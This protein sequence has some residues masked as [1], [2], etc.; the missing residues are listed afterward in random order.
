[1]L[2]AR[3]I[4]TATLP[5]GCTKTRQTHE[6]RGRLKH[7]FLRETNAAACQEARDET[8]FSCLSD[9]SMAL[10]RLW[11]TLKLLPRI[12]SFSRQEA[13]ASRILQHREASQCGR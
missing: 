4:F 13:L 12:A 11:Y 6:G 8:H 5:R 3:R 1:M 2:Q 10:Q 7:V 9:E